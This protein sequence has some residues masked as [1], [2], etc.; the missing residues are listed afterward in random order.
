MGEPVVNPG[1]SSQLWD[2]EAKSVGQTSSNQSVTAVGHHHHHHASATH[3]PSSFTTVSHLCHN[4]VVEVGCSRETGTQQ[5][6]SEAVKLDRGDSSNTEGAFFPSLPPQH[7]QAMDDVSPPSGSGAYYNGPQPY[8]PGDGYYEILG[9]LGGATPPQYATAGTGSALPAGPPT[10][11]K[12]ETNAYVDTTHTPLTYGEAPP[13]M[14][15][16]S[17]PAGLNFSGATAGTYGTASDY[18][19]SQDYSQAAANP[20]TLVLPLEVIVVVRVETVK[21]EESESTVLVQKE[22]GE[23]LRE[24]GWNHDEEVG[25]ARGGRHNKIDDG[26]SAPDLQLDWVS[27]SDS[28]SDTDSCI[29]VVS[30]Q[31]GARGSRAVDVVDLTNESDDEVLVAS[32]GPTLPSS[33]ASHQAPTSSC[34]VASSS[35]YGMSPI[36][37]RLPVST[38]AASTGTT[39]GPGV[40]RGHHNTDANQA[41]NTCSCARGP[42]LG[43]IGL[44]AS[45]HP[46]FPPYPPTS[47]ASTANYPTHPS[48]SRLNPMH[49]RIWHSQQRY[50]EM[51]RRRM[52]PRLRDTLVQ[53]G[54]LLPEMVQHTHAGA[55]A[56]TLAPHSTAHQ[57]TSSQPSTTSASSE[58]QAPPQTSSPSVPQPMEIQA[59]PNAGHNPTHIPPPHLHHHPGLDV[60]MHSAQTHG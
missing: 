19:D 52:D 49:Q 26:P 50:Q 60:L 25:G 6:N 55:T 18:S 35:G 14:D 46:L 4:Q 5:C 57:A 43:S 23:R 8:V 39:S 17:N 2:Q 27:S 54:G 40:C 36:V 42:T 34:A 10:P 1:H 51:Q 11:S 7:P 20:L 59:A 53:P 48:L 37:G 47:L 29:E 21:F 30:V 22:V 13:A 15:F 12:V 9:G 58:Q 41:T 33:A 16:S 56:T 44:S 28:D 32:A 24:A 3:S 38:N 45:A 31:R